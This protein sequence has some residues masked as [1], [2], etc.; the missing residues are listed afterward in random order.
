MTRPEHPLAIDASDPLP[1]WAQLADQIAGLIDAGAWA[2][3][4][5]IPS[6]RALAIRLGI[7]PMTVQK[8]TTHLKLRGYLQPRKGRGIFVVGPQAKPRRTRFRAALRQ[9]LRI[10]RQMGL[11][12]RQLR[13]QVFEA[14]D[15][16]LRGVR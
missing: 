9:A 2:P 1:I 10:G 15:E 8:A 11:T 5:Q 3:G 14:M 16:A 13:R 6:V 7:N 12:P 4:R